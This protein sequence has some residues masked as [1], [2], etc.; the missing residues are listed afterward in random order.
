MATAHDVAAAVLERQGPMSAMKL[1]KL[2]Y[3]CEC[4]HLAR[5]GS[6]LFPEP[7]EA[8]RQGPV[9]PVLYQRHRGRY[10]IDSWPQGNSS[11]LDEDERVL[12]DW[13]LARYGEFSAVQLSRMTHNELPWR[14]ARGVLSEHERSSERIRPE[15]M[16]TYYSR[17]MADAETAVVLAT[18]NAALEGYELDAEW[19]DR[20]RDVAVGTMTADQLIAEEIERLRR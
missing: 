19:Q 17:Q 9:V 5:R 1:E 4:W 6:S 2:V 8:W 16:K 18:A 13:V 11:N 7:I 3:Y 20:L 12:V 14:M 15:I 10:T